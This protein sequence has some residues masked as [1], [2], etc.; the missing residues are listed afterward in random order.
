MWCRRDSNKFN[1]ILYKG[2]RY[3]AV[4]LDVDSKDLST[5]MSSPPIGFTTPEFLSA[6]KGIL[7]PGGT[8]VLH[9]EIYYCSSLYYFRQTTYLLP[10]LFAFFHR[11][12]CDQ[13]CCK[14]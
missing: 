4:V 3:N 8:R 13:H 9:V 6:A 1:L 7:K 10:S 5:G 14:K 11:C 2:P 12:F